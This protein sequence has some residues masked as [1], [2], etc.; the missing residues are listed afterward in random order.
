MAKRST[1]APADPDKL[2]RQEAGSYRTADDRFEAREANGGWFLV[3]TAHTNEFGQELIQGPMSTLKAL[4]GAI[5]AARGAKPAPIRPKKQARRPARQEPPPP[6]PPPTWIEGL[7]APERRDVKRL[8]D[9]LEAEGVTDAEALVRRDRDGLMPVVASALIERRL[10]GIVDDAPEIVQR[11]LE[12][13][14]SE[15]TKRTGSLPGWSLVEIGP[16]P[17]PPNRRIDLRK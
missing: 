13:L 17:E 12:I 11:V 16:E 7:T 10:A 2:I 4:R 8:I 3:D 5:P 15:G 9:E 1:D 14:S 6:P